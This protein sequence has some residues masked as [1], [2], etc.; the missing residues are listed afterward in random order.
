MILMP[1][2]KSCPDCKD[3]KLEPQLV[4]D[5]GFNPATMGNP[6]KCLKCGKLFVEKSGRTYAEHVR[7]I[8]EHYVGDA[9]ETP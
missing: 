2:E 5:C 3:T 4:G 1:W 8:E 9:D 6:W 7:L